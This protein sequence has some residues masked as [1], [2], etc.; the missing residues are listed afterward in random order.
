MCGSLGNPSAHVLCRSVSKPCLTS[1]LV[2]LTNGIPVLCL[3]NALLL[4]V[5]SLLPF[6]K[7]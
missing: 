7:L 4:R 1:S 3:V 5:S 2:S 6:V